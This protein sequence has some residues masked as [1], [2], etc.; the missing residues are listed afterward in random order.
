MYKI[1]ILST[2]FLSSIVADAEAFSFFDPSGPA[3]LVKIQ[4]MINGTPRDFLLDTGAQTSVLREDPESLKLPRVGV[5]DFEG[6]SSRSE[7]CATVEVDKIKLDSVVI[8]Q[9]SLIRCARTALG[10]SNL[11][12]DILR[13]K[14]FS[15]NYGQREF[16]FFSTA[17]SGPWNK[18]QRNSLGHILL[19]AKIG[20]KKFNAMFDTGFSFTTIDEGFVRQHPEFFEPDAA[21]NDVSAID[22]SGKVIATKS[23]TVK[24]FKI[25][26]LDFS[27]QKI[28]AEIFASDLADA[29]ETRFV[30]GTNMIGLAD[31]IFDLQTNQYQVRKHL[32]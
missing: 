16:H 22:A 30:I 9:M 27:G 21:G 11:G 19:P 3:Y 6:A 8:R 10:I 24:D 7:T 1:L 28:R 5:E 12:I 20:Q 13:D 15:I 29:M 26:S 2:L 31:W 23:Y 17:P 32:P 25:G 4:M 14:I 18:L